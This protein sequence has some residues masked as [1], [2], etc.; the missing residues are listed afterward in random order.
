MLTV[1]EGDTN[2]I[3]LLSAQKQAFS[4]NLSKIP[5][6]RSFGW[7]LHKPNTNKIVTRLFRNL[8]ETFFQKNYHIL[9]A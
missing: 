9:I 8:K 5:I 3:S 4:D 2:V 7:D 6:I 1:V